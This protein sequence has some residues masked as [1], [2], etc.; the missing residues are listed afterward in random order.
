MLSSKFSLKSLAMLA[1]FSAAAGNA[2]QK[3]LTPGFVAPK[4][5]PY[6]PKMETAS[7]REIAEWNAKVKP[8]NKRK[9]K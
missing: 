5:K 6:V 3:E 2:I 1:A 4:L 7:D 8:R 9:S